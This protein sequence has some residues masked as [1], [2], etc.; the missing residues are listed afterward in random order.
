MQMVDVALSQF[1]MPLEA[2]KLLLYGTNWVGALVTLPGGPSFNGWPFKGG[3][4]RKTEK[5]EG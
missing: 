1:G 3:Y 5:N 4:L 2:S